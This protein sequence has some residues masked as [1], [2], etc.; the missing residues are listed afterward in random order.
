MDYWNK[1][2][3]CHSD[4]KIAYTVESCWD[5]HHIPI[6]EHIGFHLSESGIC[7]HTC[8]ENLQV[9][10]WTTR[11]I[12]SY[13]FFQVYVLLLCKHCGESGKKREKEKER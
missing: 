10:L 4:Y 7:N 5:N 3:K 2:F 9:G 12:S 8:M 13:C 6:F 11:N 1:I